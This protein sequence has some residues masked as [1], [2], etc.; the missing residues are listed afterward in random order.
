MPD[1]GCVITAEGGQ[2]WTISPTKGAATIGARKSE[3]KG[4][5]AI[6]GGSASPGGE[7]P[8]S[9]RAQAASILAPE[10]LVGVIR[11]SSGSWLF[12]GASGVIYESGTPLGAFIRSIQPPEPL[13]TVA[14]AG[15][16]ILGVTLDGK[17]L[18]WTEAEG[19]SRVTSMSARIDDVA[20]AEGGR[21]FAVAVPEALFTSEDGGSTWT[22]AQ[23]ETIG[24]HRV[25]LTKAG[26][27]L[28]Q[29]LTRSIVW[30]PRAARQ[31]SLSTS[32]IMDRRIDLDVSV[33][34]SA[35]GA[36][37]VYRRA[38]IDGDRYYEVNHRDDADEGWMLT[39]GK[40]EG[41]L[42]ARPIPD[43]DDCGSMKLGA[44]GRQIV[45]T[46]VR[47][48]GDG[49]IA[50]VRRS[51]DAGE[52]WSEPLTLETLDT[53]AMD[54]AVAP[55]GAA[56]ITGAC[57]QAE[58]LGSC[59]PG[60][61]ILVRPEERRR[62][63]A[64]VSE[65]PTLAPSASLPAFSIDGRSAY[66][67][68]PRVKDERLALF[69]SH[70]GGETFTERPIARE[71]RREGD[72]EEPS[73]RRSEDGEERREGFDINEESTIAVGEDGTLGL[74]LIG[75]RGVSYVTA[76]DDGRVLRA[77]DPPSEGA[78]IAG[79]GRR[80][81]AIS[82]AEGGS[83]E[84][85]D[86][87]R[88]WESLDGGASWTD[89]PSTRALT[90]D[91]FRSTPVLACGGGGCL[92]GE[93][94]A[95]VGWS[96]QAEGPSEAAVRSLPTS[97]IVVRAPI[98]C[99]VSPTSRW[100]RVDHVVDGGWGAPDVNESMRGRSAWSVLTYDPKI[101]AVAAVSAM[102][103]GDASSAE[104]PSAA[105]DDAPRVTTRSLFGRSPP[106]GGGTRTALKISRQMEGYAAARV[107]FTVDAKDNV[108]LGVPMRG[109]ELAWENWSDGT[110]G[111]VTLPDAGPFEL[112]DV[113]TDANDLFNVGLLSVSVRGIFVQPHSPSSR[114][115]TT[116]FLE[117]GGKTRSFEY[118]RWPARAINGRPLSIQSETVLAD[119]QPLAVG[120]DPWSDQYPFS[121]ILLARREGDAWAIRESAIAPHR[122][123]PT[124]RI[125]DTNWA[126]SGR[127]I[128]VTSM[129][130]E[131]K[132]SRASA[133]FQP[134]RGDGS[135][136]PAVAIA[137]PFDL[138]DPPRLCGASER[139]ST[140]RLEVSMFMRGEVAFPGTRRPVLITEPPPQP[141][142]GTR[143]ALELGR[144]HILMTSGVIVQGTPSSP[145][146]SAWDANPLVGAQTASPEARLAAIIPADLAHAWLFRPA[147]PNTSTSRAKPGPRPD[148]SDDGPP[149]KSIEYRPMTCRLDPS[150]KIPDAA[151]SEPGAS[152]LTPPR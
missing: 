46:C 126:Y 77:S 7:S 14:G 69:V 39:Q 60:A 81:V 136:G 79:F 118:P 100:T 137:T 117:P 85:N 59:K 91:F 94:V 33:A 44:N 115:T 56:L 96:G 12:V 103:P 61:P 65:A 8:C 104:K 134:F 146:V 26:E 123:E 24:A 140:P 18:R 43:T 120:M 143:G 68:G 122:D 32:T 88:V 5:H 129:V 149:S 76:D 95:R 111:R 3:P 132:R 93:A 53:D 127:S 125:V 66:F 19:W 48:M 25:G 10:E 21:A 87:L 116:F 16:T 70:D 101:G 106:S 124:D 51:D 4:I 114:G 152:R 112:N 57:K 107:R 113:R 82:V 80:V 47:A 97:E 86:S 108:K 1:G 148:T 52:S 150:A 90:R 83:S 89:L 50:R 49:I 36:A 31:L 141:A 133:T 139:A 84:G 40:I 67:L 102:M 131:P 35:S 17:L 105:H 99:E 128:G 41:P 98:V 6:Q 138:A 73:E 62:L 42:S 121:T 63:T 135:L 29:G 11:R 23:V 30:D 2:R 13:V 15:A 147:A 38:A 110:S 54:I 75:D 71:P 78:I 92:F 72:G 58:V 27:L 22:A 28:A 109:V 55:D 142:S 64:T 130:T 34:P 145:C 119:D 45:T 144:S 9:G 151:L 20:V 37:V 74:V